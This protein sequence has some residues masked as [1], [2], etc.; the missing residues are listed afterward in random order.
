MKIIKSETD[1]RPKSNSVIP[2]YVEGDHAYVGWL[3]GI[4]SSN[5]SVRIFCDILFIIRGH[6]DIN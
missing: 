5:I 3:Y 6:G 4:E 2:L 1:K